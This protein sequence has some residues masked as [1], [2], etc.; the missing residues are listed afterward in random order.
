MSVGNLFIVLLVDQ[1]L[2]VSYS[3]G[4]VSGFMHS[5]GVLVYEGF[6]RFGIRVSEDLM[7]QLM[8]T[9]VFLALP[10]CAL[11][12]GGSPQEAI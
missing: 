1:A 9:K 5:Y 7:F 12:Q 3:F 2:L 10:S 11:F 8:V 4:W 6:C